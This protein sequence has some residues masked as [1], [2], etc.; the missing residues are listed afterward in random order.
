MGLQSLSCVRAELSTDQ[1]VLLEEQKT[2]MEKRLTEECTQ[3]KREL[4]TIQEK[5]K[6][7]ETKLENERQ[8]SSEQL[9]RQRQG[10]CRH[11]TIIGNFATTVSR[12]HST[13]LC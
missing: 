7:V 10:K 8:T 12:V 2:A 9:E 6:D 5:K 4:E 3:L 1:R 13:L 11:K